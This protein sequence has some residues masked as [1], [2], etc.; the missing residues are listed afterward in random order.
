MA[1]VGC[2]SV[3]V[4]KMPMVAVISSGDEL[5]EPSEKPGLSQIRNTNA[6]QLMAQVQRAGGMENTMELPG[7]MKMQHM[8]L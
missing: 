3:N 6:Y 4:S 8:I 5:V 2:T 1:S 7:I